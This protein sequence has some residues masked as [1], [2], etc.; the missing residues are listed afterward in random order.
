[1]QLNYWRKRWEEGRQQLRE[2]FKD[3]L[4]RSDLPALAKALYFGDLFLA[5]LSKYAAKLL[6]L[7]A[8]ASFSTSAFSGLSSAAFLAF[9]FYLYLPVYKNYVPVSYL[10][11]LKN[12]PRYVL[13]KLGVMKEKGDGS[14]KRTPREK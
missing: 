4:L 11:S 9:V 10:Y 6:A 12:A 5:P 3:K 7:C 8:L 2:Q 1:M 13:W 14:W